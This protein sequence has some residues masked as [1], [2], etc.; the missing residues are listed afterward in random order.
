MNYFFDNTSL[1]SYEYWR[2]YGKADFLIG[3]YYS[4]EHIL[5]ENQRK[6]YDDGWREAEKECRIHP[7]LG[8][9]SKKTKINY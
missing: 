4:K 2:G 6:A 9:F 1:E 3:N 8:Y 7:T 5:E